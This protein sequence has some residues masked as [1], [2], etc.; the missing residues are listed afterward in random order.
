MSRSS[1]SKIYKNITIDKNKSKITRNRDL[2]WIYNE[3][4]T[5]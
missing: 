5:G 4:N 1:E 3:S 2:T